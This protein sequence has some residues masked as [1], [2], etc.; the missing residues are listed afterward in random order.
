MRGLQ[1]LGELDAVFA[2]LSHQTR[3]A[4]LVTLMARQGSMTSKDIAGRMANTWQTT[5]RHLRLLEEA[6]LIEVSLR[7][8]ERIYTLHAERMDMLLREWLDRFGSP[9]VGS[10]AG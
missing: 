6:G 5:S 4:I 9:E 3:R 1:E 10:D 2:A 8:R 7:G